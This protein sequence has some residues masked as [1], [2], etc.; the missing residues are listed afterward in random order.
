MNHKLNVIWLIEL[1]AAFHRIFTG[2]VSSLRVEMWGS[3]PHRKTLRRKSVL[4]IGVVALP[5]PMRE[6]EHW[7]DSTAHRRIWT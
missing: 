2:G 6:W 1:Q 4:L 3:L 5:M 7:W